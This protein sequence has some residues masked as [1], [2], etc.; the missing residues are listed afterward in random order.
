MYTHSSIANMTGGAGNKVLMLLEGRGRCYIQDRGV[1][2]WDTCAS[3]ALLEA[4]G[5]KFGKLSKFCNEIFPLPIFRGYTYLKTHV[6]LDFERKAV[7]TKFNSKKRKRGDDGTIPTVNEF[8]CYSNICGHIA[9]A[10]GE[11]VSIYRDAI[12]CVL[13]KCK[14]CFD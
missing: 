2:R 5:G 11:N 12:E 3:E 7:L 4:F 9:L 10:P 8:N 1:S 14:P 6:N 13:R